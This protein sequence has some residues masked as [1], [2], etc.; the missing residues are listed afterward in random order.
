M[1]KYTFPSRTTSSS[2]D[3]SPDAPTRDALGIIAKY[4]S[5]RSRS[6][7]KKYAASRDSILIDRYD[8]QDT[9]AMLLPKERV[10]KCHFSIIGSAVKMLYVP[11]TESAAY[12]NV[13]TCGSV[14]VCSV[15]SAK[16]SLH[17]KGEVDCAMCGAKR[18]GLQVV[19]LTLTFSHHQGDSLEANL[20]AM[21]AAYNH[22]N[23]GRFAKDI[24]ARYD[25]KGYI[26]AVEV[27]HSD[28][29]GWHPHMHVLVFLS[30]GADIQAYGEEMGARWEYVASKRGLSMNG[31]GFRMD[32]ADSKIAEYIAKFGREPG[33]KTRQAWEGDWNEAS[34]LTQ[35]YRKRGAE[36]H[37]TP[38]D[39]LRF[40]GEGDEKAA[41]LF[42]E[43][44]R[45]FKGRHQLDWTPGLREKLGVGQEK[46]DE[47]VAAEHELDK[48][49]FGMISRSAWRVIVQRFARAHVLNKMGDS[50]GDY[51]LMVD[52][53]ALNFEIV[54]DESRPDGVMF[55]Y[56]DEVEDVPIVDDYEKSD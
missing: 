29:N 49:E 2:P 25:I 45:V 7:F 40:A 4:S 44:A 26:R 12:G 11:S 53:F 46:S 30:A 22:M 51:R 33:E 27:T 37:Y 31:H 17:R 21:I 54:L 43:Y 32:S 55:K 16:V 38:F 9:A 28:V 36:G 56:I 35:W 14:W 39:L 50:K 47:E 15:C 24:K 42:Q 18:L 3:G 1:G 6:G 34:E 19:L 20:G 8:L 52:Y 10:A 41:A 13:E 23:S 48:Q 5:T